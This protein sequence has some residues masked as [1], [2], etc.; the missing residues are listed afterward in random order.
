MKQRLDERQVSAKNKIGNQSFLLLAYLLFIDAGL[1]G[2]GVHWI[3][4]PANIIVILTACLF[5]YLVRLIRASSYAP[6]GQSGK[7]TYLLITA[8]G[9]AAAAAAII[10]LFWEKTKPSGESI[11][12]GHGGGLALFIISA[13]M[14]AIV[15]IFVLIRKNQDKDK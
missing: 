11:S 10:I 12:S 4:Y 2:F 5:V 8:I 6:P 1:Y 9:A 14:L 15:G 7:K 3:P 13:V